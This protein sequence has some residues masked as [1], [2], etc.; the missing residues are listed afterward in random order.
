ML[1]GAKTDPLDAKK[2]IS[3]VRFGILER[4]ETI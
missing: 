3:K 4:T 2:K 1:H